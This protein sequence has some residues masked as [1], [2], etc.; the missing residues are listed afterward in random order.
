MNCPAKNSVFRRSAT[1]ALVLL[2]LV[3][4]TAWQ[5]R[6]LTDARHAGL[7]GA[8]VY[9]AQVPPFLNFL[10]V[11][12]G[13]FRGLAAEML[14]TRADRLQLEG[15]YL[16]MVQLSDWITWLDPHAIEAW[17]YNAWN[18][19]YNISAMMRSPDDRQRWVAS[20]IALLRDKGI[21]ANPHDARIC[22]EL[23]FYYQN[24][25]GSAGDSAHLAYKLALAS[26]MSPLVH[27]DG[28]FADTPGN[29]AAL[30]ALHLDPERM[31]ALEK[32]FG[33]LDWRMA[34]SHA[35]YWAAQGLEQAR[36]QECLACRRAMYQ[37][38]MLA[39]T[40]SGRFEGVDTNGA[41]RAIPNTALVAPTVRFLAECRRDFPVHNV[42]TVYAEF[43]MKAIRDACRA[44]Q[45]EQ[46]QQW[47]AE[48]VHSSRAV[49][50]VPPFDILVQGD[51]P[52]KK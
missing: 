51:T 6:R 7:P 46:A 21:P 14:W 37:P 42:Q 2:A 43:L 34:Q 27:A 15:R 13:G 10:A 28:T 12:M 19:A 36:G 8:P 4:L 1:I 16:E 44:G 29:R 31:L 52:Q 41:W 47:Y 26:S 5:N 39:A 24:K 3:A 11:G 49:V 20:G 30:A 25:I 32:R 17:T 38:L 35:V 33:P 22:R 18:M 50:Y 45:K 9:S 40:Q 23:A 48:L